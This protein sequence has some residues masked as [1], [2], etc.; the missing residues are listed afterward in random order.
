MAIIH[1]TNDPDIL[2]GTSLADT[3]FGNGGNDR[4]AGN[5]GNDTIRGG[6]G[7]DIIDGNDGD[8]LLFADSNGGGREEDV[9]FGGAGS[10]ILVSGGKR[11]HFNGGDDIDAASWQESAFGVVAD[12]ATGRATAG[13]FED[14]FT[15][16]ENLIGSGLADTLRGNAGANG[17]FGGSGNDVLRGEGGS[18]ELSGG[19]GNDTLDGGVGAQN[20][21]R[22]GSGVDTVDYGSQTSGIQVLLDGSRLLMFGQ[23]RFESLSEIEVVRA[24]SF[25]DELEGDAFGNQIFGRGGADTIDGGGGNDILS[26][27]SGADTFAFTAL[28]EGKFRPATDS[29]FDRITDFSRAEGDVIDLRFHKAAT[30]FSDLRAEA[31]Q[32]G[33]DTHLRLGEDTIVLEDVSLSALRADMFLF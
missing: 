28:T 30:D 24:T 15:G 1:G 8:D 23:D 32:F 4:L 11:D 27:S 16:I 22:G 31:S 17:L 6:D 2:N 5:G 26:G 33:S 18:D 14:T 25:A 12:L 7:Q 21:L 9:L 29:G 13:G 19:A 3:I 20:T 10:D